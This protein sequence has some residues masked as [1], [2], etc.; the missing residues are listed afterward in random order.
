MK[1]LAIVGAG[2][3]GLVTL[4]HALEELKGWTVVCFE[5]S[6][7]IR[8]TWGLMPERF[9]S[10]STKFTTQFACY[11]K[12]SAETNGCEFFRGSEFGDYLKEFAEA[13]SL[14]PNIRLNTKV[15]SVQKSE[16]GWELTVEGETEHF[17]AIVI[18]TGLNRRPLHD[19]RQVTSETRGETIVVVGGGESAVDLADH[20]S[21]HNRVYLS[22]RSGM[23][24]SPRYHPIRGVPSDFLRRCHGF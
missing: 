9:R 18:C 19:F 16:A 7:S 23:R 17:D 3:S 11:P 8:G 1:S 20:L 5:A 12:Y 13:F 15:Q 2:C 22:L 10:T 4:K 14:R 6:N 24:L 21:D